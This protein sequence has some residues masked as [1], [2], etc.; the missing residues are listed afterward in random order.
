LHDLDL[1]NNDITDIS[2]LV[3]N[4]GIDAGDLVNIHLND[5]ECDQEDLDDITELQERGVWV[6]HDC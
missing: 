2:P 4:L 6:D 3:E 1:L 5:L